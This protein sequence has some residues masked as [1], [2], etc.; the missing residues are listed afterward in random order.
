MH[1]FSLCS[2][3]SSASTE[4]AQRLHRLLLCKAMLA[5]LIVMALAFV[6]AQRP[7]AMAADAA[8]T[9][10]PTLS[11]V[12]PSGRGQ[13][14]ASRASQS[15]AAPGYCPSSG[16]ST[17]FEH[18]TNAIL[19]PN[20]DGTMKLQVN[21]F[22]AN[23]EGC[24]AG[25][26]CPSYDPSPEHVNAWIDWNGDKQWDDSERVMDKDLTGYLAINYAGTMTGISQFVIPATFTATT[27]LRANVGYLHDPNDVCELSWKWGSVLDQPVL[28][29]AP[30]ITAIK[31]TGSKDVNNPMTTYDVK[32]EATVE[33]SSDFEVTKVSWSGDLKPGDGNPYTYKPDKGA[34]GK[35]KIKA[36]V[37]YKNKSSGATGQISK[38]YE[39]K[40]FFEKK[41]DDNGDGKPN[42]FDYWG[43][44]GAVP[45]LTDPRVTYDATKGAGSYGAWSPASDKVELGSAAA[46][47]HYPGGLNIDG[48]TY[49][50]VRGSD[51]ISEVIAHELRHRTTI[52]VNWEAG[53]A[54]VGKTDSDFHAPTNAYYD[55]L[56]NEYEDT[57]GTDKTK[58]DSKDLE[59]KKSAVYKYYGDNEFDAI[60]AG[61]NKKGIAD[62][63]WANPGKQSN[64]AF[65]TAAMAEK[66]EASAASGLVTAASQYQ[67]PAIVLP[68]LARLSGV[69]TDT[70]VD[71]DN[72]GQQ[73]ALRITVGVNVTAPATYQVVGWLQSSTGVNLAWAYASANLSPGAQ[74]MQLDFDGKLLRLQGKNGPYK[75]GHIELR[76]GDDGDVV[77]FADNA[78]T[79]AAYT[80]TSFVAPAVTYTGAYADSGVDS[81]SNGLF[82]TL[83]IDVGVQVNHADNYTLVGWL[84]AA[85]GSAIPGAVATTAFSNSGAQTLQFDGK[86]IRWQRKNGPY[87]LR[88]LE[89]RDANQA[90][91]AFL[92]QAYTTSTAYAAPQFEPGGGA[93]LDATAYT[94]QGI[95]LNQDGLYD[96]L[97]ISSTISVT[98][99]GLYQLSAA[100]KDQA[101][102]AITDIAK[103]VNLNAGVNP[104]VTL[105]FPGGPIRQHGVNGPYQLAQVILTTQA[106][107]VIDQQT[108]AATTKPYT[109]T[110]FAF[111]LVVLTGDFHDAAVDTNH[112]GQK[113]YLNVAAPIQPG[114]NGVVI[115][116]GRLVDK[117]G[118]EIQWV[119]T[120]V[121][122]TAGGVQTVT[123]PFSATQILSHGVD[124]PY[125]LK[126][127]LIYHT[128][129][130][131]QA[132]TDLPAYVTAGYRHTDLSL[133]I[134][135]A[136]TLAVT[137]APNQL[138]ADGNSTSAITVV[139]KDANGNLIPNQEV[140]FTTT[141]GQLAASRGKTDMN[142]QVSV[143]LSAPTMMGTA[144]V[145]AS[146]GSVN[147]TTAVTFMAGPPAF[148]TTVITPTLLAADGK[149]M[150][151][152]RARVT[153]AFGNPIAG[154]VVNFTAGL[155]AITSSAPT[156][157]NGVAIVP[158]TAPITVGVMQVTASISGLQS[159]ANITFVQTERR[160]YLPMIQR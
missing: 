157:A 9:T 140:A 68:D 83:D 158:L 45:G 88:Y 152:V 142:G 51:S 89:V 85:D 38:D 154:Q 79:T 113:D 44:D 146:A 81:N 37:T 27:W 7:T 115:M 74:Q 98:T 32:L 129:D 80:V 21:V 49:G 58:T 8:P 10:T 76:A 133:F 86:S 30:Q 147:Q 112:D 35:K 62:K 39:F 25:Q 73:A 119:E 160:L 66:I 3:L 138:T 40:L 64:P 29:K 17:Q 105:D 131:S 117:N 54:W 82:D 18:I 91:V 94:D 116:Q 159:T 52:K 42:W 104:T 36:T 148:I 20:G 48:T 65:V 136:A 69:Y 151:T 92:A 14:N 141:L 107:E 63:D 53:G 11:R 145:T 139:A 78:Y 127:V 124:G 132:I 5:A 13:P 150:A 57:F 19:T 103:E 121:A 128:G 137:A 109:A 47:T 130:P 156:D 24:V 75:L 102:Q 144:T 84:Y 101:G 56:P 134:G 6:L 2:A 23:P 60:V 71:A 95:D 33:T 22:I 55:K 70:G 108:L 31:A 90:R 12:P 100:L 123:L 50:N 153:D 96:L 93:E 114:N 87:T 26:E 46:E 72:N 97:R 67:T 61:H 59:H 126:D 106:G 125:L 135:A 111:P 99:P 149:S 155:G 43:A 41:G 1:K 118:Q 122:M 110:T 4:Q 143:N 16:G 120:N 34:Q 28:L 15:N 77:D